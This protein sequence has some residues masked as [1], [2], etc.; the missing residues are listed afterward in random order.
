LLIGV[1]AKV[2]QLVDTYIAAQGID[3]VIPP[4][5]IMDPK[6]AEELKKYGS[7]RTRAS[8]MQHAMRLQLAI[9]IGRPD[10]LQNP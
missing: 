7:S 8:A 2:K 1:E 4:T 5:S 6:F 10:V 3:P 9:T